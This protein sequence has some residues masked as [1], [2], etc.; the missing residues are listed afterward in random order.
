MAYTGSI[1][2]NFQANACGFIAIKPSSNSPFSSTSVVNIDKSSL[3][4]TFGTLPQTPTPPVCMGGKTYVSS[5]APIAYNGAN[6][7]RTTKAVYYTGL[8][9]NSL[10]AVELTGLTSKDI[11]YYKGDS[12]FAGYVPMAAC[13][14]FYIDFKKARVSS[15]KIGMTNN[16]VSGIPTTNA[17]LNCEA[18]NLA[19]L[20]PNTLYRYSNLFN[21]GTSGFVYRVSDVSQK[22]LTVEYPTISTKNLPVNTCGFAEIK[23]LNLANGFD[24]TDKVKING[25]EYT[26]SSL[27][28]APAAPIC[29]NGVT[30][31]AN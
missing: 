24:A 10:N 22:K 30:Y 9:P 5:T 23:S 17:A 3:T 2:R 11:S 25:T 1:T 21:G 20:T 14:L 29:K 6:L 27:P 8:T 4:Y 28:L 7:Y 13:G 16:T 18:S 26:V 15:L 12:Q 31:K 19:T